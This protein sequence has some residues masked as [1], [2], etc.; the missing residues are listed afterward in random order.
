M[1]LEQGIDAGTPRS[2]SGSSRS[3]DLR[4]GLHLQRL[5]TTVARLERRGLSPEDADREVRVEYA[6]S[7]TDNRFPVVLSLAGVPS[8]YWKDVDHLAERDGTKGR[9]PN[10]SDVENESRAF[11]FLV[12]HCAVAKSG[13]GYNLG[14]VAASAFEA[15]STLENMWSATARLRPRKVWSCLR[16]ISEACAPLF[17]SDALD[18]ISHASRVT[19]FSHFPLGLAVPPG[20]SAPMC[21]STSIAYR[22]ILPLTRAFQ[23]EL[24]RPYSTYLGPTPNVAVVECIL[25]GDPIWD[26][27]QSAWRF[28]RNSLEAL[29]GASFRQFDVQDLS[30]LHAALE[31]AASADILVLSAHGVYSPSRN[32]SGIAV[33]SQV[34]IDLDVARLPP[35]VF[36]SSCQV[37]PRGRASVN[38]ADLLFRSH[39]QAVIAPLIPISVTHNAMLMARFCAYLSEWGQPAASGEDRSVADVWHHVLAS[40]AV[41]DVLSASKWLTTWAAS[42]DVVSEFMLQRSPGRI[43]LT[44]LY[45]DTVKVL[46]EMAAERGV[47]A[48]LSQTLRTSGF[49]PESLFYLMLGRPEKLMVRSSLLHA[50][51]AE[52]DDPPK[53]QGRPSAG[54]L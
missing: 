13:L 4:K 14:Q 26:L 19:L 9:S 51:S 48:R 45:D 53:H 3:E 46:T 47:D 39:T 42:T 33:G 18:L 7:D 21:A 1:F 29:P 50:V 5:I 32:V 10:L 17:T 15:L 38:I 12:T 20:H 24:S 52:R 27:S 30:S 44:H 25:P 41:N 8:G 43:R 34:V 40:N 35:L 37:S 11:D 16:D 28:M 31:R 2:D 23:F 36:L 6:R 54:T 22:P 49:V